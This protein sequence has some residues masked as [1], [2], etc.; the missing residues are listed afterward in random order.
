MRWMYGWVGRSGSHDA[1]LGYRGLGSAVDLFEGLEFQVSGLGDI[2]QRDHLGDGVVLD[3]AELAVCDNALP[4]LA[5]VTAVEVVAEQGS[6][7][8]AF[9]YG[10]VAESMAWGAGWL[11][12][13]QLLGVMRFNPS[14]SVA[15]M[16]G[17][18]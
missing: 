11:P 12:N 5:V 14:V 8:V 1:Q 18:A 15:S 9:G 16:M 4:R 3:V 2:L 17:C 13:R 7:G 10:G 6:L